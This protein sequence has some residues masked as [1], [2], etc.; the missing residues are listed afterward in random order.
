[1]LMKK[2]LQEDRRLV[3]LR[4]LLE[5]PQY[6]ANESIIDHGLD[7]YGHKVSRDLVKA[8]M[9]WLEEQGLITHQDVAGTLV[10]EL[11]QRGMDVATGQA[12]YPGV[13]R[14]NPS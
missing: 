11:T 9:H 4:I 10:A 5:M 6:S 8:E 14:P 12:T 3:V 2:L 1:M 7:A 13:K